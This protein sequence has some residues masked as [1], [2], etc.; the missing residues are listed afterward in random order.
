MK[1]DSNTHNLGSE[2]QPGSTYWYYLRLSKFGPSEI[3]W[4]I[5][6]DNPNKEAQLQNLS[7]DEISKHT[8]VGFHYGTQLP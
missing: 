4:E 2:W 8:A 1:T 5:D 7:E 6:Y 3:V